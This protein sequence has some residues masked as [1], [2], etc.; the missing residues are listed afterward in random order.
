SEHAMLSYFGRATYDYLGKYLLEFNL[1]GDG[2]SRFGREK[3]FGFFPSASLGWRFV[4][5]EAIKNMSWMSDGKLRFSV[6]S[7]GNE[8]IGDYTAKGEFALGSNYLDFSGA[9]P[10]VMPNASLTWET[11]T[12]YNLGLELGFLRDRVFL[13][14]DAYL[15]KTRDLLYNVPIPNTTGFE[16]ITQNIG[17]IENR[18]LE[19]G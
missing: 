12:Q 18:G 13:S 14:A 11:T 4:E 7:T 15:K 5:E 9:A 17:E 19:L 6:G 2:S 16:Y 8:A 3:R 1:R 10:T